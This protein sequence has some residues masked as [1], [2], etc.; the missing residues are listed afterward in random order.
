MHKS[1][2]SYQDST[3]GTSLSTRGGGGAHYNIAGIRPPGFSSSTS[4]FQRI[5]H[6]STHRPQLGTS[7]KNESM[8]RGER[9]NGIH[10][11]RAVFASRLFTD[12]AK[13]MRWFELLLGWAVLCMKYVQMYVVG[14]TRRPN[15]ASR[16]I[17]CFSLKSDERNQ[18]S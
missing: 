18:T 11:G 17:D 16:R 12:S 7:I 5:E 15:C 2:P 6:I 14:E 10:S 4:G 8:G 1:Q 9:E 3:A 13:Y